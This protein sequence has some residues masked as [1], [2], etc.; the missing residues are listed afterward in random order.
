MANT[1]TNSYFVKEREIARNVVLSVGD[2]LFNHPTNQLGCFF[3]IDCSKQVTRVVV[4]V[5]AN[6]SRNF[7]FQ[8][9]V[10]SS[11]PQQQLQ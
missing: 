3:I 1:W 2:N 4:I 5:V 6:V 9:E 7:D 8:D 10:F 11:L